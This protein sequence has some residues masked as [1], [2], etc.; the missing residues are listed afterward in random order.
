MNTNLKQK[1]EQVAVKN[2]IL[3]MEWIGGSLYVKFQGSLPIIKAD[4]THIELRKIM[5]KHDAD[6]G[7]NL[8]S[9][10][11]EWVYDFVPASAEAPYVD[12]SGEHIPDGIDTQINLEIEQSIGK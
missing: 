2:G 4:R 10:G 3:A 12:Y 7:V 6:S 5:K 8:F 11:D 1:L 9:V